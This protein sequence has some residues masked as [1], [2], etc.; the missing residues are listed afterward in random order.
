MPQVCHTT[1]MSTNLQQ[2]FLCSHTTC[3]E[4]APT[5]LKLLQ[6]TDSFRR[7]LKTFLFESVFAHQGAC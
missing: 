3:M 1:D 7:K 6:S 4:Q 2:S 5:D